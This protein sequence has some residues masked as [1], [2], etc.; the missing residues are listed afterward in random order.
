MFDF[1]TPQEKTAGIVNTIISFFSPL[2]G[3]A[4]TVIMFVVGMVQGGNYGFAKG[5]G[6]GLIMGMLIAIAVG[7][8]FGLGLAMGGLLDWQPETTELPVI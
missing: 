5:C 3:L 7:L 4:I 2:I 6:L 1:L 8:I